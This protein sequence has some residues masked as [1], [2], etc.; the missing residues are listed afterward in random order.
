VL[1]NRDQEVPRMTQSATAALVFAPPVACLLEV[2]FRGGRLT[3][4]GGW[5]WVAEADQTLGLCAALA[6][7]IPDHRHRRGRHTLLELL[8]QRIY[9]IVAGYADQNDADTL[10]TDPLLK[11]VCGRLPESDPDLA[12]QPTFSRLENAR[13]ARDC[14][15]LA[16][17]LGEV[18]LRERE[19]AGGPKR[20]VLDLDD[21]FD[22]VH[23]G[24]QLRLF[25]AHY[26][27]YGFQPIV[28]FDGEGR[29]VTAVLRP[30][31]RPKGTDI[32]ALLRRLLR[33]I[34]ANWPMTE[35]LL[36][37]DSH[38]CGPEVL[39]W[40]RPNGVDFIFGVAPTSTLRRHIERLE[41][42]MMARYTAAPKDGKV[43]RYTEF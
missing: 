28:V 20:I 39:D 10:R 36:H 19:R 42:S 37:A 6:T 13:S 31:K 27:E 3:S 4:D 35:I 8:R 16:V 1:T 43:R 2:D 24:Q 11:L 23:G 17:A 21:T 9:Q 33:A 34:R 22:A 18:Y 29:F 7:A 14:Y 30:A 26:N 5:S 12:S 25:N 40:C 41:A 38:S 15:R 32:R